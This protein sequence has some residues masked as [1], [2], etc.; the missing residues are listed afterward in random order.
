MKKTTAK[1]LIFVLSFILILMVIYFL[2]RPLWPPSIKTWGIM[3]LLFFVAGI[4]FLQALVNI[5]ANPPHNAAVTFLGRRTGEAKKEGWQLFWLRPYLYNYILVPVTKINYDLPPQKL[6]TPDMA[7]LEIPLSITWTPVNEGEIIVDGKKKDETG[8]LTNYLNAGG[9]NGVKKIIDDIARERLREW[10][11]STVEGP[12]TWEEALNARED[13]INM[14]MKSM[15]GESL[16]SISAPIR[17][18]ILLRFYFFLKEYCKSGQEPEIKKLTDNEKEN[19]EILKKYFNTLTPEEKNELLEEIEERRKTIAKMRQ[20]N[21]GKFLVQLGI[22]LDRL[23]IDEI[24]PMGELTKSAEKKV[25]EQR[26]A[27][28]DKVR[29]KNITERIKELRKPE[30]GFSSEQALE[31]L[32]TERNKVTKSISETKLNVS[33]ETRSMIEKIAGDVLNKVFSK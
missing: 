17:T 21:G 28:G 25:I 4:T 18:T 2:I 13:A 26:E 8:L 1:K 11:M 30:L 23:N 12:Q 19:W 14:I 15:V 32:Q 20:G 33:N 16:K 3:S 29:I 22:R 9:E 24:K 27:E 5:P 31:I 6:R 7:E 10:A